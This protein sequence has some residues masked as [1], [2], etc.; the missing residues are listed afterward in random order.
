MFNLVAATPSGPDAEVPGNTYANRIQAHNGTMV[1]FQNRTRIRINNSVD[2]DVDIDVDAMDIGDQEFYL[3]IGSPEG[4]LQLAMVCRRDEIQLGVQEGKTIRNRN[5]NQYRLNDESFMVQL[6]ANRT[7][8]EAKLGLVMSEEEAVK[9]EWAYFHEG[10]DE[11][12]PVASY[13]QNGMLVAETDHF[14][15]WGIITVSTA[16]P[17]IPLPSAAII[18]FSIAS[19]MA[20]IIYSRRKSRIA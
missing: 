4:D 16:T 13:Y 14:S 3:E 10:D 18:G 20:L 8:I 6:Q 2:V 7:T 1:Q 11:W 17:A 19:A 12:V 15:V 5:R 9:S